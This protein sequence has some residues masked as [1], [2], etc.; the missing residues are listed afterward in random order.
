MCRLRFPIGS[1]PLL[2]AAW[3]TGVAGAQDA[4]DRALAAL[5]A[6]ERTMVTLQVEDRPLGDVLTELSDL[7]PVPIDG[8]WSTLELLGV[9]EHTPIT[10]AAVQRPLASVL[11]ELLEPHVDAFEEPTFEYH[12]GRFY[13]TTRDAAVRM[14]LF[15][16]YDVRDLVSDPALVADLITPRSPVIED[17]AV[18]ELPL[19]GGLPQSESGDAGE[20][21]P[22]H[23][24]APDVEGGAEAGA[25]PW[26]DLPPRVRAT[27]ELMAMLVEHVD[28]DAWLN[29]GGTR[30]RID[31]FNELLLVSGP[32]S[33]HRHLRDALQTIRAARADAVAMRI[34]LVSLPRS[35]LARLERRHGHWTR[36][37]RR[38]LESI[39]ELEIH[40]ETGRL[41]AAVGSVMSFESSGEGGGVRLT[42]KPHRA[43]E[44]GVLRIDVELGVRQSEAESTL[45]TTLVIPDRRTLGV[46]EVPA[47]G[48]DDT[49]MLL[50]IEPR[51]G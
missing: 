4:V 26:A 47:F 5:D 40:L 39:P 42:L 27:R 17:G 46:T 38:D 30:A 44:T 37:A 18:P 24:D 29:F 34:R 33:L 36:A 12:D 28:P 3:M 45:E 1:W 23:E 48:G 7:A 21:D 13:L 50:V 41:T 22:A 25:D 43:A 9:D 11:G 19:P 2:L 15:A 31:P 32:A 10:L 49:A 51:P 6:A 16:V 8:D 35:E 14:R 20:D